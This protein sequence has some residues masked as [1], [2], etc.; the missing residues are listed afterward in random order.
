[1]STFQIWRTV[2]YPND[3]TACC[4]TDLAGVRESEHLFSGQSMAGRFEADAGFTM[5]KGRELGE[6]L[7]D[8]L[9][10][11]HGVIVGSQRLVDFFGREGVGAVEYHP[12]RI[13]KASGRE[14]EA[15][16]AILHPT[17]PVDCIDKNASELEYSFI[18]PDEIDGFSRLVLD[19]R[20]VPAER[21]FFKCAGLQGVFVVRSELAER[22]REQGFTGVAF[23]PL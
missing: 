18:L 9:V 13:R 2:S 1:M 14:L 11:T 12:V 10:N 7:S 4:L 21:S 15:S 5:K 8:C 19:E 23:D 6:A 16:Y 3:G 20:R 17:S 22:I